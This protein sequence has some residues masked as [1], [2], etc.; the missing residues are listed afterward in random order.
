MVVLRF[1]SGLDCRAT[2]ELGLKTEDQISLSRSGFFTRQ[3]KLKWATRAIRAH[4]EVAD[5]GYNVPYSE[6][7]AIKLASVGV[8][9]EEIRVPL[10]I[11]CI[12]TQ[13]REEQDKF[14]CD[15]FSIRQW[16][17]MNK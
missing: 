11:T 8:T 13:N 3:V 1:R 2:V 4:L 9:Q 5:A 14:A 10:V 17:T 6:T 7:L 12:N 16:R 15:H